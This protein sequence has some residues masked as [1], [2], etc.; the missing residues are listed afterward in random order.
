MS[1]LIIKAGGPANMASQYY[2]GRPLLRIAFLCSVLFAL[3]ACGGGD[4]ESGDNDLLTCEVPNVP[5]ASGTECVPPPPIA[6][7]APTVPNEANDACVVGADPSLPAPVFFPDENQAVLYYNRKQVDADNSPN[8]PAYDGWRLHTWNNDE[9][10]AYADADTDWANGRQISGID[11]TYGA[12]WILD[13][14]DDYGS[15][16]NFI[17]HKGTDDAGKE[18]GG[19]D[20]QAS[21]VQDDETYTRMNFTLSG[22]PTL[23]EF[24]IASLGPQPV[25]IAGSAAHWIDPQTFIWQVSE[26]VSQVKLHYSETADLEPDLETGLEGEVIELSSTALNEEQ[27]SIYPYIAQWPAFMANIDAAQAKAIL[28]AQVVLGGY[29]AQGKLIEAT[30]VQHAR[31][32]DALYTKGE[33]D[34]DEATLGTSYQDGE[35]NL[36]LWAPT[37]QSVE[38]LRYNDDKTLFK[39]EAMNAD[40]DTGIWYFTGSQ[41]LDRTLYRF[42]VTVY[43]P[44]TGKIETL[45]V[46]D[47]YSESVTTNG[48]FSRF[49]NLNDEDL[50][51]DNWDTHTIPVV[52][53]PE[54]AVIYEVHVRDFSARDE[55]VS[56]QNRG[57]YLAFTETNS[58]PVQHLQKLQQAG[59]NYVH[60][61]PLADIA[62]IEEDPTKTINLYDTIGDLCQLKADAPVC[63][64]QSADTRIID[65]YQSYDPVSEP[66]KAQ[67]LTQQIRSIDTFNWGYDP[68]HFNVPEGSY[69][70]NADSV[71]RI[72]ELRQM[73]V[74]LHELGLRVALDVV[75]NHTNESGVF[76]KSVLDK[77]VPGY[78][79]RYDAMTGAIIQETCCEDTEPQNAMMEKL[80]ADSLTMWAKHYKFD[81]FRFDIMSQATVDTMVRLR[82]QVQAIDSD[83]YFYGEGW[84]KQYPGY[85]QANQLNMA[86][87]EIGT[88]NDRLREA[89]RQ[90]NIF[91][92]ES[93]AAAGDQ[94]KLKVGLAGTLADYLLTTA[95]GNA[96]NAS[97]LGGYAK[98]PADIINYVSKHDNETLWDQ[99]NY[100]LPADIS[101]QQRVRIQNIGTSIPL[102]SQGIPFL[103]L[104][105]DLL[106][107]KSMDR[108]TYDAGDWFNYVDF[109]L[110]SNNWNVGLPLAEDNQER[111]Q[112]MSEFIYLP[113]RAAGSSDIQFAGTV[114]TEY[115]QIRSS[116]PLFRLTTAEQISNRVGFHNIGS[117]QQ[118]GLIAMSIDDGVGSNPETPA[119]DIDPTAD[120]LMVVLNTGYVEKSITVNTA[121]GFS[122]HPVQVNSVDA[123]VASAYFEEGDDGNGTFTVPALTM[124]VFVQSQSGAQGA[125][126]SASATAGAPDVVPYGDTQVFLRG[127]MNGWTTDDG[128]SYRGNG[129]Y[130][131]KANL[132]PGSSYQFKLASQDWD[133]V[134]LG[135]LSNTQVTLNE[136]L[137][138]SSG[139]DN[140]VFDAPESTLYEFVL[141]ASDTNNPQVT[142]TYEQPFVNT[143]IYLRGAFND[144]GTSDVFEYQGNKLYSTTKTIAAGSYEFKVASEDWNTVNY[145]ALSGQSSDRDLTL[146]LQLPIM[147]SAADNL[148]FTTSE[149]QVVVFV[150]DLN[151]PDA[152]VIKA[153]N[154]RFFGDTPVY[155]RGGM[156]GW[157]IE[158]ELIWQGDGSYIAEIALDGGATEFKVASED[159]NTVNLGNPDSATSNTVL[160]NQ[161]KRLATSN[162]NLVIDLPAG[163][164]EFKLSGPDGNEPF[165]LISEK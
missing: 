1:K 80:M 45:Q 3:V 86:G 99:F 8:D 92:P 69:A 43:S 136:P 61:L 159:W 62:S 78:Y 55:T 10:D 142:V 95:T 103:Q 33:E 71:A 164:Y 15:C 74:A 2:T 13:L 110:T 165:I 63:E 161:A 149:D 145:G 118:S 97:S 138:L 24:P 65:V 156:N 64:E 4:V 42:E 21:L 30:S 105:G 158:N 77:V 147:Q 7:D 68:H 79:H 150:L 134:N 124:A 57:K 70:T 38:L 40:T 51:P 54:D 101:L 36:A 160:V 114:F 12:Y 106:R 72:I 19:G 115:L 48:R 26:N 16:H 34:A 18:L 20:F 81:S 154:E 23:F 39:R 53:N 155:V 76:S 107:S 25:E 112:E 6:C 139:G 5:D 123:T 116:S 87:T 47:P 125:G 85:Q 104:G 59:L 162:N 131:A 31:V 96:V 28:R 157:G 132:E 11:P 121:T 113:E 151:N 67:A 152:P 50:K 56:E 122:L 37:A 93:D 44:A 75:F 100:T 41:E 73:I 111:W 46:T 9:C 84:L 143:P 133:T 94:D 127:D 108:N 35:I 163:L 140:L 88:F 144:W 146:G 22:E 58:A 153:F 128:F 49:V 129:I 137:A 109:T 52:N 130:I 102:M 120:A 14:K 91:N 17:V 98:D 119:Q 135:A 141:D 117:D 82:D 148:V 32:L 66:A 90:G 126:L 83:N 29:D 27:Q 60:L 89:V